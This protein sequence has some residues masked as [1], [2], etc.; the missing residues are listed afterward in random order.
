MKSFSAL[1]AIILTAA[2][3]FSCSEDSSDGDGDADADGD[4]DSDGDTDADSDGDTDADGD[5]DGDADADADADITA[6][7][8]YDSL[9]EFCPDE[10]CACSDGADNDGDGLVD[11]FDPEC[12]SPYDNDEGT[13]GTG[14]PGDNRDPNWQDCYFD[15]NSGSGDDGCRYHTECITAPDTT[16]H[17]C[18]LTEECLE[19]CM[20]M[21]PN[22]CDCFGCCELYDSEGEAHWVMLTDTCTFA[23][24]DAPSACTPC[25]PTD[26][27]DNPCGE[28]EL[29]LGRTI[30][31]LPDHCFETPDAGPD[32]GPDAS[33]DASTDSGTDPGY[34]CDDGRQ[35]CAPGDPPCPTD[36]WCHNGCCLL[37]PS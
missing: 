7:A 20:P 33:P 11:G 4:S 16:T 8:D 14:I 21:V 26:D 24:L 18:S 12:T 35:R 34:T 3:V 28:C 1:M 22:G 25:S 37:A 17:D 31:D 6:D 32:A 10:G 30:E 29:C 5:A 15:G 2:L 19:F 36:Y 27:C 23:T 9:Q 13:F